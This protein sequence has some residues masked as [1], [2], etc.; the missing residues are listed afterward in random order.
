M[1]SFD[2]TRALAVIPARGKSQ[3]F[4]RKHLQR[5]G[6]RTLLQRAI[7]ASRKTLTVSHTI[8]TTDDEEYAQHAREYGCTVPFLRPAHLADESQ[9][10]TDWDALQHAVRWLADHGSYVPDAVVCVYPTTP[11]I[12]PRHIES[13]IRGLVESGADLCYTL[14]VARP[15]PHW[16]WSKRVDGRLAP[17]SIDGAV[18]RTYDAPD[19]YEFDGLAYAAT[20]E[21][22][23]SGTWTD[24]GNGEPKHIHGVLTPDPENSWDIDYPWALEVARWMEE[25]KV[26]LA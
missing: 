23:M 3:R 22:A 13:A 20:F 8:L 10:Y 18:N 7:D 11:F 17:L 19:A 5:V 1:V 26:V 4:P 9:G 21:S 14:R 25:R 2:E 16:L 24:W 6:D 15:N 12:Q